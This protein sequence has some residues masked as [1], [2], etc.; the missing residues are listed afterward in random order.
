MSKKTDKRRK[1]LLTRFGG[2]GD[3]APIMVTAEQLRARGCHV[4]LALRSDQGATVQTDLVKHSG[5]YDELLDLVQM[6][7]WGNR[8]VKYKYGWKAIESI[9]PNYDE[10]ID[11]MFSIEGNSPCRSNFIKKPTDEWMRT[12]GSNWQNWYDLSL[13]WANIDPTTV[14]DKDKRP[15][16]KLTPEETKVSTRI[17]SKYKTIIA[18]NPFASSLARTWYQAKDLI[19]LIRAHWKE[20]LICSWNPMQNKWEY[21]T[22]QGSVNVDLQNKSP[23]RA[24]MTLIHACDLYIS[25]DSGFGH[26]AE[27][28]KKRHITLYS[29]VPSWTRAKYYQYETSIDMGKDMPECYTFALMAGDPL[30]IEEGRNQLSD[31]EKRLHDLYM[32]QG[33]I[34]EAARELNTDPIGLNMELEALAKKLE[35]FS[36][37]QSKAL[38]AV[39]PEMVMEKIKELLK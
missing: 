34:D 19:P 17:R 5:C 33:P 36:R 35:S 39:T 10:I 14:P 25:V 4:T 9:Y 31:R 6:G 2:N 3:I 18:I 21:F 13:S 23:L 38:T 28:L 8:C 26:V 22:K 32:A 30:R 27:G 37:L 24:T 7:P 1:V 11:Y 20:V 12:R 16:F 15:T 29:T